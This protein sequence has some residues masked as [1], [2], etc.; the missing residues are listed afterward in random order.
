M[1]NPTPARRPRRRWKLLAAAILA[2]SAAA[3]ASLPWLLGTG[4]GRSRVAARLN[5][6]LAPGRLEFATLRLSWFGPTRLGDFALLDPAGR[7][8][9]SGPSAVLDR[10][11]A[12]LLLGGKGPTTLT[13]DGASLD[14]ER[15][16]DGK[17]DLVEALRALIERPDPDRD[18]VIRVGDGGNGSLR[19]RDP[20]LARPIE[21]D[22][23]DLTLRVQA[24]PHPITW[25]LKL[26][27]GASGLEV[28]GDFDRWLSRGGTAKTPEIRVD[29]QARRWPFATAGAG[30]ESAGQL[31]GTIDLLRKRGRWKLAG[32]ARLLGLAVKG[33]ILAGDTLALDR[34]DAGW[35]LAEGDEGWSIRRL[36]VTSP[37]G[38]LRA[39][40]QFVNGSGPG[41]Q[42]VEGKLDLAALARQFP[43]ALRLRDGLTVERGS[44]RLAIDAAAEA[45]RSTYD[46]EANI[47][48]LAARD[49]DRPFALRGPATFSARLVR[50]AGGS[51]VER[52][53]VKTA[54]LDASAKGR[55]DE[56]VALE[57]TL[58][59]AGLRRQL[60]DWVDLGKLD[61]A[62][63]AA[64][65]GTYRSRPAGYENRLRATIRDLRVDGLGP[66]PIRRDETT[67]RFDAAGP[68]GVSGLPRA[69]RSL[70]LAVR[71]GDAEVRAILEATGRST[72]LTLA[73]AS[74]VKLGN[75]FRR[76]SARLSGDWSAEGRVLDI[77]DA[78]VDLA[79]NPALADGSPIAAIA[80]GRLDLASGDLTLEPVPNPAAH[81]V[82]LGPD[83]IRVSG[84]GRGLG[85]LRLDGGLSGD[86]ADL[87]RLL[88]EATGRPA[89]GLDGRWSAI[90]AAR[91]DGDGVAVSGKFAP[92]LPPAIAGERPVRPTSLALRAHYAPGADRV[93][94]SEFTVATA[95]GTLDASGK[96]DDPGGA[97]RVDLQGSVAPDFAAIT[98]A[99][100]RRVEPGARLDG[101]PRK[102]HAVGDLG[103]GG[104]GTWLGGLDAEVGFDLASADVYGMKL[105]PAP[106]VLT[107]RGGRLAVG[108][109]STTLNEGH[110]RLEPEIDLGAPGGPTL[111]LAKNS[112]IRDARINDE[113]SR[114]V[115][116]FVAPVL[117]QATRASGRV[118]VDLDHAEFPLG[119]GRGRQARV[120][121]AVVFD[122]VQF[123][124]GPL[125]NDLLGALGRRDAVLR[126]DQPV[127]LTIADG[128]I[129]Q[130]GLAIP[131]GDLTRIDL[132]GWVDFDR[133][134]ALTATLPVTAAMLGN[135][136]LLA[137]IAAGT[138]VR[139]PITG[140][141]DRPSIDRDA[142][143]ANLQEAG[144]SLLAR[145]ATRGALELLMR[146]GRPRDPDAPPPPPRPSP[147]QRK[148]LRQERKAER[149]AN[150]GRPP[151]P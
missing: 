69:W 151:G 102:F 120:E 59:L 51:V 142:L 90:A 1:T 79:A 74:P 122:D 146:L 149:R 27:R 77:G 88:A 126:L 49:L 44:A 7:R 130:R 89:L 118:T 101:G 54:F 21:A 32:D 132:A 2:G 116:A 94:L 24:S 121:G 5:R 85:S 46:V 28:R 42:R 129:N 35:D 58:D 92:D 48:D 138:Q 125:A 47:V 19:F 72:G 6:A 22:S 14:I 67:I 75:A 113:V 145:G 13:L 124:P 143:T 65:S 64:I 117:D 91:G 107:A 128:R 99:L 96:V 105:G 82:I 18:L 131:I 33:P 93:D 29:I 12:Q 104:P 78:R 127:T 108:P 135:N 43:H 31:D 57:G 25:D 115:L 11:F 63:R 4:P 114:R 106:I 76:A 10:T 66:G 37:L 71:S 26:A 16:A 62:G 40:G 70:D 3:V 17:I 110:V 147:E 137:D 144:K 133:N 139:V 134:L 55:L 41:R 60:G 9:A 87:D 103:A 23:L 45:G 20:A 84:I 30:F 61:L 73:A 100:A 80:R 141:L 53:A 98:A 52:L 68:A 86:L 136:A 38:D 34:V 50:R 56:G 112:T 36:A 111:R 148:A 123:A 39:E 15:S 140:T 97:R 150:G 109:I 83:G 8:V 95:F 81:L 119:P